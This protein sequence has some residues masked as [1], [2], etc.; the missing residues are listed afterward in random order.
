MASTYN[1]ANFEK[2]LLCEL[3]RFENKTVQLIQQFLAQ[4]DVDKD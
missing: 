2:R 3:E 1:M 4:M